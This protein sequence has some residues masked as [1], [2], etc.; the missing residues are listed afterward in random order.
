MKNGI[1]FITP[2]GLNTGGGN[3]VPAGINTLSLSRSFKTC[4]YRTRRT[5]R[6]YVVHTYY[7]PCKVDTHTHTVK[8]KVALKPEVLLTAKDI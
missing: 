4:C 2:H 7:T 6:A 8:P 1:F 5:P 3:W